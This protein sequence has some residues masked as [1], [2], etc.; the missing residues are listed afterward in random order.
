MARSFWNRRKDNLST[1]GTYPA[2]TTSRAG[3]IFMTIVGIVIIGALFFAVFWGARWTFDKLAN[4]DSSSLVTTDDTSNTDTVDNG[5]SGSATGSG[6]TDSTS[7]STTITS[8]TSTTTPSANTTAPATVPAT[9]SSNL[10]H[11]GPGSTL[12]FFLATVA[13]SY[14]VYRKKLLKD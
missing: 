9:S 8:S 13:I 12:G 11:T 4:G 1:T 6:S 14:L 7:P 10:P 2:T 3:S 5:P